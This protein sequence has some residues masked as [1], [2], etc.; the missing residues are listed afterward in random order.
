MHRSIKIQEVYTEGL[1]K[2][3]KLLAV[4]RGHQGNLRHSGCLAVFWGAESP[5]SRCGGS[6]LR[7]VVPCSRVGTA[8]FLKLNPRMMKSQHTRGSH[9]EIHRMYTWLPASENLCSTHIFQLD[10]S[11]FPSIL[12]IFI[13]EH[14]VV[15]TKVLVSCWDHRHT[16]HFLRKWTLFPDLS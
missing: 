12:V 14:D 3:R 10:S 13:Q 7:R 11:L 15:L 1:W 8:S 9:R 2:G 5:A 16:R 4:P 6:A